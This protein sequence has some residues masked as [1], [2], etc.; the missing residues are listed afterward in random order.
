MSDLNQQIQDAINK[1]NRYKS[2]VSSWEQVVRERRS[3]AFLSR[4]DR[5]DLYFAERRLSEN[6]SELNKAESHLNDLKRM[7]E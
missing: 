1:V 2:E 7:L 6:Q 5:E 4:A 3:T